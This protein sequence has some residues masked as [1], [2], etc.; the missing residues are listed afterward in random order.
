MANETAEALTITCTICDATFA[1]SPTYQS[2]MQISATILETL[3][4]RVCHFCFRCRR[5]AC[6][7]C[8][9]TLHGVCGACAQEVN[10]PFRAEAPQLKGAIFSPIHRTDT[11]RANLSS[12]ALVC[13][14]QGRFQA[15]STLSS[16]SLNVPA[17]LPRQPV[18]ANNQPANQPGKGTHGVAYYIPVIPLDEQE[19]AQEQEQE[20]LLPLERFFKVVERLLTAIV[21]T[22]LL[23]ILLLIGLAE[24]S[25]TANIQIMHILHVDI[26]GEIAYLTYLVRQLHW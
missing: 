9:D 18:P 14:S 19:A 12:S 13:V 4:M 8:W 15:D 2:L 3:F 16:K 26:R 5:L 23:V 17:N 6:P 11:P 7:E 24:F 21:F 10:L 22:L 20:S 25:S 1:P